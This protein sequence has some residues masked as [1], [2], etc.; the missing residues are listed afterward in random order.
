MTS[1][2]VQDSLADGTSYFMAEALRLRDIVFAAEGTSDASAAP[3]V[4]LIDEILRG[5]NSEERAVATRFIVARL[6]RTPAIGIITTHDLGIFKAAEIVAGVRHAH[7]AEKFVQAT[8]GERLV[9][10]HRLK[11][12]PTTSTNALRLLTLIGLTPA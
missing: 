2:R 7:F 8:D 6:L 10:D 9:F 12:G 5:T 1:L 11:E 4:Y 3:V